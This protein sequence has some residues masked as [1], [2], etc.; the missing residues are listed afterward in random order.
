MNELVSLSKM[1]ETALLPCPFT[2]TSNSNN[3]TKQVE[4]NIGKKRKCLRQTLYREGSWGVTG[5][6]VEIRNAAGINM[7]PVSLVNIPTKAIPKARIAIHF[8]SSWT[9]RIKQ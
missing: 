8:D 3:D 6:E 7:M 4:A 1:N 2:K 5:Q 9:A